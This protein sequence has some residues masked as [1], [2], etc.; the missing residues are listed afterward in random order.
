MPSRSHPLLVEF[1][2]LGHYQ[3]QVQQLNEQEDAELVR[4]TR[5]H[6]VGVGWLGRLRR[7]VSFSLANKHNSFLMTFSTAPHAT[8]T[9]IDKMF[10]L[11]NMLT[12]KVGGVL[13]GPCWPSPA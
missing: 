10:C 3:A 2:Q 7:H 9:W 12:F 1:C 5:C 13:S 11:T 6:S 4:A 8:Q